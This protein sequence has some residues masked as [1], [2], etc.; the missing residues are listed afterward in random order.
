MLMLRPVSIC[1]AGVTAAEGMAAFL[2]T[3]LRQFTPN[4]RFG[5]T[6]SSTNPLVFPG[7]EIVPGIQ[8]G[9]I[10][11]SGATADAPDIGVTVRFPIGSTCAASVKEKRKI[12]IVATATFLYRPFSTLL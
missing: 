10:E 1:L 12:Y 9:L 11:A 4:K 2:L 5:F 7:I 3:T 6:S 8:I